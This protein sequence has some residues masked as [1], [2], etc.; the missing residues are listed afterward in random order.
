[1]NQ[2][3][4]TIAIPAYE[5][6][7]E[8][9]ILLDSIAGQFAGHEGKLE[10]IVSDDA[11]APET[12]SVV[13]EFQQIF[14][15]RYIKNTRNLG[16]DGNFL[17]CFGEAR[18]KYVWLFGDD[19]VLLPGA[20]EAALELCKQAP[21]LIH[22]H[23]V[24]FRG[25]FTLAEHSTQSVKITVYKSAIEFARS[26]NIMITF[27][28][29]TI[30]SKE[31]FL[32]KTHTP[33]E[34]F[35][36]THLLHLGWILQCLP[37]VGHYVVVRTPFIAS[38]AENTG[39]YN[40][41]KV[42]GAGFDR[43]IAQLLLDRPKLIRVFQNAMLTRFFPR[44]LLLLREGNRAFEFDSQD[45]TLYCLYRRNPRYWLFVHPVLRCNLLVASMV[46]KA[47]RIVSRVDRTLGDPLL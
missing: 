33:P 27:L 23:S 5:R 43:I 17:Q 19:D 38:K 11:S 44:F 45:Q 35:R 34:E 41:I 24:S 8:L 31:Y 42:F 18:G 12:D 28:S 46:A 10:V 21:H 15:I 1:M 40:L 14:P 4:L 2:P 37:E 30:A 47:S 7:K 32:S 20:V 29:G 36:G 22:F 13:S 9:G 3:L 25:D 6:P 39:G 26:V 16:M